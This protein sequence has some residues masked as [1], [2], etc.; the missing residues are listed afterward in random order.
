MGIA[1][2]EAG[3][4]LYLE[5]PMTRTIGEGIKLVETCRRNG[6]IVRIN[7]YARV[8]GN[9][10]SSTGVNIFDAY[11]LIDSGLLGTPL[12]VT[13]AAGTGYDWKLTWDN[14]V[15]QTN[16]PPESVPANLDYNMWL[17]P[18]PWRPY[19]RHRTHSSFRGYWDYDGG[20]LGDMGFHYLDPVQ[21]IL[22]KDDTSP[23]EVEADTP[24][25]HPDAAQP[26]NKVTMKYEDGTTIICGGDGDRWIEGPNGWIGP[27]W[28]SNIPDLQA[29]VY[30]MP[31][32]PPRN[33]DFIQNVRERTLDCLNE[34]SGHRSCNL[35]NLGV[36]AVRLNR[37][38]RFDP[39]K[40]EFI[41]DEQA[42]RLIWQPM[43]APWVL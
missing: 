42:N 27:N 28:L 36:I 5:K 39:V 11:R 4:D 16:T 33:A 24:V 32:A 12:T 41:G 15:G 40:Q 9:T 30:E 22:Q 13:V 43:R 19:F 29:R 18:A 31:E 6:T 35:V 1:A 2:A 20:G 10:Q 7:T 23:V 34:V 14:H 26:W 38:L 3:K 17:G 25:Q 8:S 37:K 21:Y